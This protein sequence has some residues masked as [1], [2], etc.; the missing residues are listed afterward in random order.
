[1][2]LRKEQKAERRERILAAARETIGERGYASLTMRHLA[3]AARVTVPTIYNLIGGKEAVLFAAIEDQTRGFLESIE[4]AQRSSPVSRALAVV[5]TTTRELLRL[6]AYYQSLLGLLFTSE[7]AGEMRLLVGRALR[8]EFERALL[9]MREAGE[10]V[11]W[12][13]PPT[14]SHALSSQLQFTALQWMG[15]ELDADGLKESSL[16]GAGLS[17]LAVAEG[18]SRRELALR[19]ARAQDR[20]A[21]ARAGQRSSRSEGRA[22]GVAGR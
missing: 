21:T 1:M 22:R 4:T 19:V 11:D 5:E 12:V 3:Q 14:L 6:P 9:E 20:L 8:G 17:L 10:L 15:G 16:Y 13:D 18:E 7:A 2:D